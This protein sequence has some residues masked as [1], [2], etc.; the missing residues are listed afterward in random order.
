VEKA[1]MSDALPAGWAS[2]PLDALVTSQKGKKP[3]SLRRDATKDFVPYLDIHAIEQR[4]VRQFADVASSRL[5]CETDLLVVWDGARS[6]WV[7]S[8]ASGAV[9]STIMAL[10]S[11]GVEPL[12]L[13]HFIAGQ[14]GAINSNTRGTGIPHVDPEF[15]WNLEV[16][17]AP[18]AEQRRIAAKLETLLGKVDACQRRLAKIPRLLK[19]FRQSVL[20]AACSGRLTADWRTQNPAVETGDVLL[21]RIREKRLAL[22]QTKKEKAQIEEVFDEANLRVDEGDPDEIPDTWIHCRVGAIGTVCNGSTPSRTRPEFWDGKIPWVSS[23]QVRNN[24]V[25]ETR[26]RITKAG[27]ESSSVRLL[28][29]GTVLLA[30]IGEGKTRGQTAILNI[31]ATINQNIA[32][33]VLE[34]GLVSSAFLWRWFQLQNEATRER[35]SGSGPQALNCQRVRE[36]PFVLPPLAEQQ[37]IVRRVGQLFTFADQLEARFAKAQA[38]VDKLTQSLLAKAFRGELVPQDPNGEPASALLARVRAEANGAEK[39]TRRK[40]RA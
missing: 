35:G 9:G 3:D 18:L 25:T 24:A 7:G 5:A 23:G 22:A 36:I 38:H 29:P 19:R 26:E 28:P 32:A 10:T 8:G 37:E 6:G 34:H 33:V 17:L 16:P 14:F 27:Y 1:G 21:A 39:P 15:F 30:M 20:A 13:R 40:A 31:E 4:E 12:Y 11:R 2:T